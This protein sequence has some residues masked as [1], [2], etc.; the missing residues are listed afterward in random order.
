MI[1]FDITR[2][3]FYDFEYSLLYLFYYCGVRFVNKSFE[4]DINGPLGETFFQ[5]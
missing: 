1:I 3:N 2:S 4:V 5:Q